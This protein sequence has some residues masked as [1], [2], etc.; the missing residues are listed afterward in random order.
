MASSRTRRSATKEGHAG[1]VGGGGGCSVRSVT[2]RVRHPLLSASPWARPVLVALVPLL[3][4]AGGTVGYVVLES[5][6]WFDALY[7]AVITLMTI[8]YGEVHPLSHAGRTFTM[9]LALVGAT[10]L[11]AAATYVLRFIVSG[12]LNQAFGRQRMQRTLDS[13]TDH[14][15]LCGFGRVGRRVVDEL[16][17]ADVPVVVVDR[18]EARLQALPLW[19]AG[20]VTLDETLKRAG[21]G[22]ARALVAAVPSDADNLYVTMSARLLNPRLTIVARAEGEGTEEKLMRAGATRVISPTAIGGQRVVQAVLRPAV[23]DFIDLATKSQHLELQMEQALVQKGSSLDGVTIRD[24][25]LRERCDVLVVAVQRAD[26]RM[27]FNPPPDDRLVHGERLV[28][29][30]NRASLDKLEALARA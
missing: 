9:V 26:G 13:V 5:W 3:L 25:A 19:V 12:E 22:R 21:I 7:M 4:I 16:G 29:L 23:L 14:V 15:I 28:V 8:G 20:D 18:D 6:S 2:V 10:T 24:A 30:G 27:T 17:L 1:Y 11:A